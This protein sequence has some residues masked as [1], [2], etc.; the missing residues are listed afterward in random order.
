MAQCSKNNNYIEDDV[1]KVLNNEQDSI[2]NLKKESLIQIIDQVKEME[3]QIMGYLKTQKVIQEKT[4]VEMKNKYDE[5]FR[6]KTNERRK[7]EE[8]LNGIIDKIK[9]KAGEL[10]KMD[11]MIKDVSK[12][13][14]YMLKL[15]KSWDEKKNYWKTL[16]DEQE[17]KSEQLSDLDSYLS[18]RF[19]NLNEEYNQILQEKKGLMA[20]KDNLEILIEKSKKQG[21]EKMR[22]LY[23]VDKEIKDELET[24]INENNSISVEITRLKEKNESIEKRK[25]SI[26][27]EIIKLE[28]DLAS[29][30]DKIKFCKEELLRTS[31]ELD[32]KK[33]ET[34]KF[35]QEL[36]ENK[37]YT[38]EIN[39]LNIC[40]EE[41]R[42]RL[43]QI[44]ARSE[45]SH[46][47]DKIVELEHINEANHLLEEEI[48]SLNSKIKHEERD[49]ID[50]ISKLK[51]SKV[52][53][54]SENIDETLTELEKGLM[55][56]KLDNMTLIEN[57]GQEE[58]T[59]DDIFNQITK[60]RQLLD[61]NDSDND[62][63]EDEV[64]NK[65]RKGKLRRSKAKN[66]Q[67]MEQVL[68]QSLRMIQKI[69][70]SRGSINDSFNFKEIQQKSHNIAN[71]D[72]KNPVTKSPDSPKSGVSGFGRRV[73]ISNR[74]LLTPRKGLFAP[75]PQSSRHRGSRCG[76]DDT[77]F[78]SD[79]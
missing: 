28:N 19:K 55:G 64:S 36:I 42:E 59:I 76:D 54:S 58:T 3:D 16:I 56:N 4:R 53:I 40:L 41:K 8:E 30:V 48:M 25:V 52:L 68:I 61:I 1:L 22:E 9:E 62:N 49:L 65:R 70:Q 46:N 5:L 18:E 74:R 44:D 60:I 26:K 11:I 34:S 63:N 2:E 43:R 57:L 67:P 32:K 39:E 20:S 69:D 51:E 45:T 27:E 38:N 35:M 71:E 47:Y 17:R 73:I 33:L 37:R 10:S 15:T 7:M 24:K 21:E 23:I 12:D 75:I 72:N 77:L 79:L 31:D 13:N 29:K 6:E 78:G 66:T 50:E 14:D